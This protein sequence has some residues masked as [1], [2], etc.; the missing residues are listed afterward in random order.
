MKMDCRLL[1]ADIDRTL[2]NE[3]KELMPLTRRM[4]EELHQE[5]VLLCIASGRPI[6]NQLMK[7]HEEWGLSFQFDLIIGMNGGELHDFRNN[8]HHEYHK[9]K[10]ESI[11]E[12][13]D[14]MEPLNLNCFVYRNGFMLCRRMDQATK[15]SSIRNHEPAIAAEKVED[16]YQEDNAK[17]LFRLASPDMM[18]AALS[19]AEAHP[20]PDY[21]AFQTGP[22]VLEFQDPRVSKGT[23][24]E[25]YCKAN[26][27]PRENVAAFG[28]TTNDNT[29]IQFAGMGVAMK[30]STE[31]TLSVAKAI[32]EYDAE[33]DGV[34]H[35][36]QD[37]ILGK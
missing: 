30:N 2:V 15:E 26:G 32:T 1:A 12:I 3:K 34:G 33:H 6:E 7:R 28:D 17:L 29:M 37:H 5:G 21:I 13:I 8:T 22:R 23:A 4:L 11:H 14:M 9:L 25:E 27:I 10:K 36:I 20:S 19:Y 16:L 35:Y 31:D 24:L 18:P